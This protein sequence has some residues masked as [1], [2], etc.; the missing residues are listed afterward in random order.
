MR[1]FLFLAGFL[2]CLTTVAQPGRGY[3]ISDKKAIKYYEE[4]LQA[5]DV[6]NFDLALLHLQAARD[7]EEG[8]IEVYILQGQIFNM[9]GQNEKAISSLEKAQ[10]LDPQFFPTN[11]Y[12]LGELYLLEADYQK[13]SSRFSTYLE[14]QPQPG[15]TRDRAMLG[16]ASC[17]YAMWAL[18][19]PVPFEP[20]NLGP[21]VNTEHSEYYPSMTVDEG[22]L[23]F[24]REIPKPNSPEGRDEDFYTATF[25]ENA[26]QQ[27]NPVQEVNTPLREGA[28]S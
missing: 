18:Q 20:I 16:V 21:A 10:A 6:Q 26:W 8:V 28:P 19:N 23:L 4:A 7:R 2:A 15:I 11:N 27:A 12:Y 24:T 25:A 9:Q 5:Y 1:T 13:A 17:D 14:T 3:S 22:Q